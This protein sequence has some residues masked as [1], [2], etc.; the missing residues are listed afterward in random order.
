MGYG[1]FES[2][3]FL[4]AGELGL[5]LFKHKHILIET[6]VRMLGMLSKDPNAALVGGLG[7]VIAF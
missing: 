6:N 3:H 4:L 7:F 2:S 1:W 5:E